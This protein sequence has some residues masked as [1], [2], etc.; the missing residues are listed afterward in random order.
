V[1][2]PKVGTRVRV[3]CTVDE[4]LPPSYLGR[5]GTIVPR[6]EEYRVYANK[7]RGLHS[8]IPG[9]VSVRFGDG[10]YFS[11]WPEELERADESGGAGNGS[12][13]EDFGTGEKAQ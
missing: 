2:R 3:V 11:C 7:R 5:T 1:K 8:G 4:T 12:N 9:L 10:D 6:D 13:P